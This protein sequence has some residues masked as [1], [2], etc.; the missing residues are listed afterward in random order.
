MEHVTSILQMPKG[1]MYMHLV[2]YACTFALFYFA[3]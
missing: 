2:L 3:I 1:N